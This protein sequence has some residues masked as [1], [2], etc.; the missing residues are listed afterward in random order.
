LVGV[1]SEGLASEDFKA[2]G[3]S[4]PEAFLLPQAA[5]ANTNSTDS[6][7]GQIFLELIIYEIK[8]SKNT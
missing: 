2:E 7:I 8:F 5:R 1:E 4:G 3:S 6:E